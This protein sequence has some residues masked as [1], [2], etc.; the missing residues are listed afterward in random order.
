MRISVTDLDSYLYWLEAEDMPLE[1]LLVRLRGE[2]EPNEKMFAGRAFHTLLEHASESDLAVARVDGFEFIFQLD[3][4]IAVPV[5]RELKGEVIIQT[6]FGPVTLVGKVDAMHGR[7]VTDY[8]LTE[9]FDAERYADSYQWRAYLSMFDATEFVYEAFE[10][11]YD[12]KS[13]APRL[14]VYGHQ[15]LRFNAYPGMRADL[16]RKVED[17]AEIVAQHVPEKIQVAA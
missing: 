7:R 4:T 2:E 15:S 9:R 13:A 5:I 3:S 6:K 1:D 10:Y 17:L 14:I 12:P 11:R 16:E 8:K